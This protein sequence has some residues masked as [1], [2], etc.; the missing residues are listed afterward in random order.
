MLIREIITEVT[1]IT[2]GKDEW[3][4]LGS[5]GK[6]SGRPEKTVQL[7]VNRIRVHEPDTKF[8]DPVYGKHLE[9]VKAALR[10]GEEIEPITV[11]RMPGEF[12]QYQVLDGHHRFKA[13]RDLG[14]KEIPAQIVHKFNVTVKDVDNQND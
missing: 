6:T 9:R 12:L 10:R 2:I 4:T 3:G 13:Y 14:L 7:P 5:W 1:R 8:D 11:R